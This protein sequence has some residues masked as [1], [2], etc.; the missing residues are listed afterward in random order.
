MSVQAPLLGQVSARPGTQVLTQAPP[1]KPGPKR[2]LSPGPQPATG[3]DGPSVVEAP[4]AGCGQT[5]GGRQAPSEA[6]QVQP[7]APPPRQAESALQAGRQIFWLT[8][9]ARR[10]AQT[11]PAAQD[12]LVLP[13]PAAQVNVQSPSSR[14]VAS[15]S[16]SSATPAS[17]ERQSR[18]AA[19]PPPNGELP[20]EA[21]AW[22]EP[23]TQAW[24]SA[25]SSAAAQCWIAGAE[26]FPQ[27]AERPAR[28]QAAASAEP[29]IRWW[30]R[31]GT[32]NR[33]PSMQSGL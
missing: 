15:S 1:G 20:V 5:P 8:G 28:A 32:F 27:A 23:E 30:R 6:Q 19:Q 31:R 10:S 12:A 29:G 16:H 3:H 18:L 11:V 9:V 26:F 4:L 21:A 2:Q 14:P 33:P 22:Q 24:S 7:L 17:V 25:Q 13:A